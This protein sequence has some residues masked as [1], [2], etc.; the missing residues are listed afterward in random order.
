MHQKLLIM[1]TGL[2]LTTAASSLFADATEDLIALDMQWGSAGIVGDTETT[3]II[4]S[5]NLVAVDT[6][7]VGGKQDQLDNN[8]PAPEGTVYEASDFNV[9]FITDDVAI[10]TH[11]V[12]GEEEHYSMHVWQKDGDSWQVVATAS[13]PA[14]SE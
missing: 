12:A 14:E 8:E 1:L 5:D 10:M 7:G 9:V 6:T 3:A 2:L 13:V 11:S 4:L